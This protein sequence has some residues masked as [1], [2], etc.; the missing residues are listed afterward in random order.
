[1]DKIQQIMCTSQNQNTHYNKYN[2]YGRKNKNVDLP[3]FKN[4]K[5]ENPFVEV[6]KT[7]FSISITFFGL[8][9]VSELRKK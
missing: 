2:K 7:I 5:S 4:K 6:E 1:M 3:K 9:F 8:Q